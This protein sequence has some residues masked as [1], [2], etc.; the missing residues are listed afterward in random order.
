MPFVKGQSGNPAAQFKPGQSGNPAG[1]PKGSKHINT[2]VQ[3]I[4]HDEEFEAVI[5]EGYKIT[6]FKGAPI[7]AII[8]AQIRKAMDGDTMAYKAIVDSGWVKKTEADITSGGEKLE[9]GVD[10]SR[11]EQLIRARAGRTDI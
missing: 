9:L 5:R 6:E 11:L 4:L 3:E 1:A 2:W 10:A 7:K 8:K